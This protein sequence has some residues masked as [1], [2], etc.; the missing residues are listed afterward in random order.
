MR[1][2]TQTK[3]VELGR[4]THA[5]RES[6]RITKREIEDAGYFARI[7]RV[8]QPW[9]QDWDLVRL[10]H[11]ADAAVAKGEHCDA[12]RWARERFAQ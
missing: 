6:A 2:P 3:L 5:T 12:A 10:A 9:G 4:E 11:P 8:P 1:K 7:V